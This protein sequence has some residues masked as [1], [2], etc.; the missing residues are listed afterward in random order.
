MK[1]AM[2][3]AALAFAL[4][5][6]MGAQVPQFERG[7]SHRATSGGPSFT[8][9]SP[10]PPPTPACRMLLMPSD[11]RISSLYGVRRDPMAGSHRHHAGIDFANFKSSAVRAAAGGRVAFAGWAKGCGR[12]VV[13][14]HGGGTRTRYCHL[15]HLAVKG[16]DAVEAGGVI[17]AMGSTGRATGPHLHFELIEGGQAID[18][19]PRLAF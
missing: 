10:A 5:H 9:P 2:A 13:M 18:P 3:K 12:A 11:G 14:E 17:G 6:I 4:L 8:A 19:A 1:I 16:G 7:V 15:E